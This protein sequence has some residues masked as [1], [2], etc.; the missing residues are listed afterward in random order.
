MELDPIKLLDQVLAILA[1]EKPPS[2]QG[3][4]LVRYFETYGISF[5]KDEHFDELLGKLENDGYVK[6]EL[7]SNDT[8]RI[9]RITFQG[10]FFFR[11][12][13][14]GGHEKRLVALRMD[15]EAQRLAESERV[16]S[17]EDRQARMADNNLFVNRWIMRGTIVAACGTMGFL[18]LEIV[19]FLKQQCFC[20]LW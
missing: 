13:G 8:I 16:A 20:W 14:Y 9:Y 10:R 3:E 12:E 4:I 15:Q 18:L 17:I 19:K 5:D 2:T 1:S 7:R 6:S 11:S